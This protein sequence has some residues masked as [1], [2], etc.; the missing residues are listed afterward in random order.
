[1][2]PGKVRVEEMR[3]ILVIRSGALG[4]SIVTLP[5]IRALRER[6]PDSHIEVIG[7]FSLLQLVN[8]TC[9]AD[10]VVSIE[11]GGFSSF[12]SR[13]GKLPTDW[14][15]YFKSFDLVVCFIRDAV[16][17]ENIR[18][19]G[20]KNV[21]R[22]TFLPGEEENKHAVDCLLDVI[23]PLE[24]ASD[25][26]PRIFLDKDDRD[27]ASGFW[28][29]CEFGSCPVVVVHPGSGSR[30]KM[31]PVG[32]FREIARWLVSV[33]IRV[34]IPCGEADEEVTE[35]MVEGFSSGITVIREDNLLAL[36]AVLEQCHFFLGNDSGLS[37]LA[38]ASGTTTFC[39]FGP[40][41]PNVWAPRGKVTIFRKE[42]PC[43][44]CSRE[45]M[46]SC[47]SQ[48]CLDRTE[49]EDVIMQIE[50]NIRMQSPMVGALSYLS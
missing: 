10:R 14:I 32:R 40:T 42:L 11:E 41:D 43:S 12:F 22:A 23:K 2:Y 48:M 46:F 6:W 3:G 45:E 26:V 15:D 39:I 47:E 24:I 13:C 38:A 1:M 25:G 18:R 27:F 35:K 17:L 29:K 5:A 16:L 21:M 50:E 7:R 37:H 19:A 44:P 31:W 34:L 33:G 36:G 8:R 28:K 30:K 9:Y 49:S 20:P 4:D